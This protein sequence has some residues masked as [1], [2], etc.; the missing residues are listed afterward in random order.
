MSADP[1]KT[2]PRM[3][4]AGASDESIQRVHSALLREKPEPKEGLAPMP[5]MLLGFIS[6]MI[7]LASIYIVH[8]RGGFDPLV[9]DERFDPATMG[10]GGGEA[11]PVDPRVA[12]KRHYMLC[13]ACHQANGMGIPSAFPSLVGS[14]RVIGDPERLIRIVLHGLQGPIEGNTYAG[15]MAGF[16]QGS[17]TNWNDQRIAEV[18]TYIRS[19][20][21][22]EAPEITAEQ[23]TAVR[24]A[25]GPRTQAWTLEELNAQ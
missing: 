13:T 22:N 21:G 15:V 12:G 20:W 4:Q 8:Y 1:N 24:T 16:G 3:E 17:P 14:E 11:G 18:L 5:L 19:D 2:N 10:S 9:Y 23:V 25:V 7:F 6:T